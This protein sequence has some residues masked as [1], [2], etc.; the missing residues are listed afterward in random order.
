MEIEKKTEKV[1][2]GLQCIS[3]KK[4]WINSY[5]PGKIMAQ[6]R[7]NMRPSTSPKHCTA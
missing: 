2:N 6:C 7:H 5:K 4:H 3:N 1:T